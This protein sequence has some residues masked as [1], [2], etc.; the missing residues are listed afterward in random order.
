[1]KFTRWDSSAI[2]SKKSSSNPQKMMKI[3]IWDVSWVFPTSFLTGFPLINSFN[4]QVLQRLA[5]SYGVIRIARYHFDEETPRM[6]LLGF[7]L[8][9]DLFFFFA[10]SIFWVYAP[11]VAECS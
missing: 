6:A 4:I 8:F 2:I 10:F 5:L 3:H 9:L 1:M 7:F 11:P